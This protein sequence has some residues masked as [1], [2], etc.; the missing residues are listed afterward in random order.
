MGRERRVSGRVLGVA[1]VVRCRFRGVGAVLHENKAAKGELPKKKKNLKR[2]S[3]TGA[4]QLLPC[5]LWNLY[6]GGVQVRVQ[7]CAITTTNED[8]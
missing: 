1:V 4:G 6:P 2:H 5:W 3:L 7:H 8:E